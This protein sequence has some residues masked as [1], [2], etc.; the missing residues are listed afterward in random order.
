MFI[1]LSNQSLITFGSTYKCKNDYITIHSLEEMLN[2]KQIEN[3]INFVELPENIQ[4][5]K[6]DSDSD[7]ELN[8]PSLNEHIKQ[9][10]KID[11]NTLFCLDLFF[12]AYDGPYFYKIYIIDILAKTKKVFFSDYQCDDVISV[13]YLGNNLIALRR[14]NYIEIFNIQKGNV[15]SNNIK[16]QIIQRID[17][18]NIVTSLIKFNN[19][20]VVV[21]SLNLPVPRKPNNK[22]YITFYTKTK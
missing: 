10:G 15:R 1:K 2:Y 20:F 16:E 9:I 6:N 22:S 18:D 12:H 8:E 13:L 5:N 11:D 7:F 21:N 4:E 19:G 3:S 14:H 17:F